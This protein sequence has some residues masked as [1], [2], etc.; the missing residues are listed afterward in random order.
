MPLPTDE[1]NRADPRTSYL[2]VFRWIVVASV[3]VSGLLPLLA[4]IGWATRAD[5]LRSFLPDLDAVMLPSTA[6]GL[7]LGAAALA[8][9]AFGRG[10]SRARRAAKL[11]AL[12][13][14]VIAFAITLEYGLGVDLGVDRVIFP[15]VVQAAEAG[16]PGRP[17]AMTGLALLFAGLS[18]FRLADRS[19]PAQRD[20][21]I[22]ALVS[23]FIAL[24]AL[25]GFLY[26]S[27]RFIEFLGGGRL[28]LALN[29]SL[30]LLALSVGVLASTPRGGIMAV[31]T[32]DDVGG[33]VARRLLPVAIVVPIALEW[34]RL[35]GQRNALYSPAFGLSL[36]VS[37]IILVL[38]AVI[39]RSAHTLSRV[40]RKRTVAERERARLFA[41]ERRIREIAEHR[42]RQEEALRRAAE[43]V[44]ATYTVEGVIHEIAW[45]AL[46]A[47]GA[48]VAFVEQIDPERGELEIVAATGEGA[49]ATGERVPFVG[50]VAEEVIERGE[51]E[52]IRRLETTSSAPLLEI[53]RVFPGSSA[54]VVPLTAAAE[55][56]G[57]LILVRHPE[58]A[59]FFPD[60]IARARTF[61]DLASLAFRKIRL[62]ADSE[63]RRQTLEEMTESRAR[64]VRGFSHDLKNPLGAADGYAE[65]LEAGIFGPLTP[66]Q[67]DGVHRIRTALRSALD[68]I[69]DLVDL[70]RSEAGQLPIERTAVDV[71]NATGEITEEHRA[72]A[73]AKGQTLTVELPEA[74]P[75][76]SS[77]PSRIHQILGNLLS[78]AVKFTPPGGHITVSA[79]TCPIGPD[80]KPGRWL[81][82]TV[83]DT[84]PGI[85][86]DQ[87]HLLFQEFSR[88]ASR[89]QGGIGLGLAISRR[90]ARLLGGDLTVESEPGRGSAFTLWL[91]VTAEVPDRAGEAAE[92]RE[93]QDAE[94][95]ARRRAADGG[96]TNDDGAANAAAAIEEAPGSDPSITDNVHTLLRDVERFR[97]VAE[98]SS[99]CAVIVLDRDGRV[100]L[101]NQ[102]AED[103]TGYPDTEARDRDIAF[104]YARDE[105][106][107]GVPEADLA[108]ASEE[109]GE[110]RFERLWV[111]SSGEKF[112]A[113]ITLARLR[114]DKGEWTGYILTATDLTAR[115][116]AQAALQ[117]VESQ[118]RLVARATQDVI[119]SW[120][121]TTGEMTWG[122]GI[123][124]ILR[125]QP[126]QV[127]RGADWWIEQIHPAD[128]DRVK[129][130]SLDAI[131]GGGSSWTE[132]YRFRRA[133]GSYA[134]VLDRGY[135]DRDDT[136]RPVRMIGSM[137]D[138]TA[139]RRAEEERERLMAQL[140][141]ERARLDTVLRY[142]PVGVAVAEAP[143][144]RI[145]L[146]N[147]A[148]EQILRHPPLPTPDA[149]A[150]A[151]W[152]AYH[153]DGRPYRPEE[154][155]LVRAV[156]HGEQVRGEELRYNRGDGTTT[157]LRIDAAPIR[158]P[159]GRIIGAVSAV[160][161][162]AAEKLDKEKQRFLSEATA[163]LTSSLDVETMLHDLAERVVARWADYFI[164]DLL[165]ETTGQY[166]RV[167]ALRSDPGKPPS[168]VRYPE[169]LEPGDVAILR[170]AM[171]SRRAVL[172]EEM[173]DEW[174]EEISAG[175][176]DLAILRDVRPRS[177]MYV[178]LLARGRVLGVALFARTSPDDRFTEDD[179]ELATELVHRTA[180]AV[181]NARLFEAV[182]DASQAKSDFLAVMSHELRTPLNAI[183]GYAD[184]LLMGVPETLPEGDEKG[185]RRILASAHHLRELIEEILSF[186]RTEAGQEK[187]LAER[188]D[189]APLVRDIAGAIEPIARE[190]G[191]DVTIDVPESPTIVHT[192]PDKLRQILRN[193]LSNAV[194][195]TERGEIRLKAEVAGDEIVIR[196]QDTGIGIEPEFRERIFEP[197]WQVERGATRRVAG[198]GLGLSVSQRLAHMIGGDIDVESQPGQGSTFTI[199]VP[200]R[201]QDRS[202]A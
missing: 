111:R 143:S 190:K 197:F 2:R 180:F 79:A 144:G 142:I 174:L 123:C 99:S 173:T 54:L 85:P 40:D 72:R 184:L 43:A 94:R 87:Q 106:V 29:T 8:S 88:L 67:Q 191:L 63:K 45:S 13:A 104:V 156:L 23:G 167:V 130:S 84:G 26:G 98:R 178:P 140:D 182:V 16:L 153:P 14:S 177:A 101:W 150:Y 74:L 120:D 107:R 187:V 164:V 91:L 46:E 39:W 152:Q 97:N 151:Q 55:A 19:G 44:A 70:A 110:V 20:A 41:E 132:E 61:A 59:T 35:Q 69:E 5:V 6:V 31:I 154:W 1:T 113:G 96:R 93:R 126:D 80:R 171:D 66:R 11:L 56:I 170:E 53:A 109:Q 36:G 146:T 186:S 18:L 33:R 60:E 181:D 196:V 138:I 183:I 34:L 158:D 78:N 103:I 133:D 185:V 50:S 122:D 124:R 137:V 90:M 75:V 199:R 25:I 115:K 92:E 48:D 15:T 68:L 165:D 65:L 198:T 58:N 77:D 82:L 52:L 194:K 37:A 3:A 83:R 89:D 131:K 108:D 27:R 136:G 38:T 128:R 129:S 114:D 7:L 139:R 155:P 157:W 172:I 32:A 166:R 86:K 135:I 9:I 4:L 51:P 192:D 24:A 62:L 112:R 57:V 189:L 105:A 118:F 175:R 30:S 116:R 125:Y 162:I 17:S 201:L 127:G 47:T 202:T 100:V 145:V 169:P 117:D 81:C 188:V 176:D 141:A 12:A 102:G 28:P 73:D 179:L 160:I 49:P 195:F 161:D 193:I 147:P 148:L 76:I 121:L 71:R 134:T 64:F 10:A 168:V 22:L 119:W 95:T 21:Q 42:A 159:T 149:E 163:V 200:A